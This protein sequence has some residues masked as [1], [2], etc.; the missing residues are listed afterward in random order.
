MSALTWILSA[1]LLLAAASLLSPALARRAR[2]SV[3]LRAQY[4]LLTLAALVTAAQP[5]IPLPA[6][7]TALSRRPVAEAP[8][9]MS[10]IPS[11]PAAAAPAIAP[12]ARTP[13]ELPVVPPSAGTALLAAFALLAAARLLRDARRLQALRR[14]S[15]ALR[16][17]GRVELR[18]HDSIAVALSFWLPHR[19]VVLVPTALLAHRE[20]LRLSVLHEL[21]HHRQRDPQWM[22]ALE[23]LRLFA[24]LNPPVRHW[25]RRIHELQEFAVDE[26]LVDQSRVNSRQ[27][28][29]CLLQT[30]QTALQTGFG[31]ACATG[32]AFRV[33][34][35][36]LKR[37]ILML[38]D[39]TRKKT[40][41]ESRFVLRL[42]L[43]LVTAV[44]ATGALAVQAVAQD[45]RDRVIT[46]AEA[47]EL[48]LAVRGAEGV[49]M[50]IDATVVAELNRLLDTPG[51]RRDVKAALERMKD[52]FAPVVDPML[53]RYQLP[54][55]LRSIPLIESRNR[56]LPESNRAGHGAGLWMFLAQ[57]ARNFG[58]TV[59][60]S[61][62]ERLNVEKLTDAAGRY[63]KGYALLY[64]DVGLSI[65]A[66]NWGERKVDRL[67]RETGS[68]D[69][70]A[71]SRAN[72][73][74][75]YLPSLV[76]AILIDAN[77]KVV[78]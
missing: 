38:L 15:Y 73:G 20:S 23:C 1:Q 54:P 57:T 55:V 24:W 36:Q 17:I 5:W 59:N 34:R 47:R 60:A 62:D 43:A 25:I 66:Y 49:P 28:A 65:L 45:Q 52:E 75:R 44:L 56:N 48:S 4:A 72:D 68:R 12:A 74:D 7:L 29:R 30:A 40:R 70:W 32:F 8:A 19:S 9:P 64:N 13:L 53:A 77:P 61:V 2:S 69:A 26:T 58:L 39:E 3:R 67:I 10:F 76:A 50:R 46:L 37:R 42:Q 6:S 63:L 14:E 31:P 51:K 16:R 35:H 33:E 11:A 21:Q 71:L 18:A 41:P 22:Y 27:Y 78:D